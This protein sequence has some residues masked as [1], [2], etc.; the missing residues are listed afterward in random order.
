MNSGKVIA[1]MAAM[2][3]TVVNEIERPNQIHILRANNI[4]GA[5]LVCPFASA[6]VPELRRGLLCR[7]ATTMGS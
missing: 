2:F 1:M 4:P 6:T 5:I 7:G 3:P